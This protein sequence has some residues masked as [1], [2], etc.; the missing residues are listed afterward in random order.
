MSQTI[1]LPITESSQTSAA[2]R[3]A[4]ALATS[5]GFDATERERVAIVAT[6]MAQNLVKFATHG[7]LLLQPLSRDKTTGLELLA[8]DRGPGMRD[9]TECLQDGFSTVGTSGNGLGAINRLSTFFDWY[10][11]PQVGTALLSQFWPKPLLGQQLAGLEC[12]AVCLPMAGEESSGDAWAVEHRLGRS[13]FLVVDGLGH[14][15]AAA[16]AATAAVKLF[17]EQTDLSPKAFLEAAH[18]VLRSTRGAAIAV[19]EVDLQERVVRFAGVG[20]IAGTILSPHKNCGLVSHHGT[21]GY[22]MHRVQEF[23]YPWPAGALLVMHSDGLTA[24]WQLERY[25]GL[26]ARHP[27]LVAGVLYRDFSRG[28]DDVAVLVARAMANEE[29]AP[30]NL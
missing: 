8:L 10:S 22:E 16:Q 17:H 26:V 15:L 2:R 7:E 20:N 1:A 5:L 25:V 14:G 11:L 29:L 23:V 19:A 4:L 12:S 6:E 21:V 27:S 9:L 28:R 24:R 30:W 13:L 3:T 18:P